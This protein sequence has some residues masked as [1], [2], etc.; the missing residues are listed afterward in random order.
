MGVGVRARR[1]M[2]VGLRAGVY[3]GGWG[4]TLEKW[5][6][7]S[8]IRVLFPGLGPYVRAHALKTHARALTRAR[9]NTQ[10][11]EYIDD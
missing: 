2:D 1:R 3:G 9:T 11:D 6:V 10:E 8:E 7:D 5:A 4:Q